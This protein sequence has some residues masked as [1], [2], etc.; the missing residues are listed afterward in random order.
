[1]TRDSYAHPH[2]KLSGYYNYFHAPP[3]VDVPDTSMSY[4]ELDLTALANSKVVLLPVC[5]KR[6][7]QHDWHHIGCVLITSLNPGQKEQRA[8]QLEMHTCL[9][10]VVLFS[11]CLSFAGMGERRCFWFEPLMDEKEFPPFLLP[12]LHTQ[13]G[14]DKATVVRDD[15]GPTEISCIGCTTRFMAEVVTNLKIPC[16]TANSE[17]V[18]LAAMQQAL[19]MA[20]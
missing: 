10:A 3:T 8:L 15:Q 1:M 12:V 7:A 14:F 11:L 4:D 20:P 13:L 17:D 18:N 6:E 9:F 5:W 2:P 19:D 16:C